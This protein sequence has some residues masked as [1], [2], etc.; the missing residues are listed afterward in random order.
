MSLTTWATDYIYYPIVVKYR[1]WNNY[2]VFIATLFTFLLIG[3]WHG[4]SVN[5]IIFGL[6][7]VVLI[8]FDFIIKKRK[9]RLRKKIQKPIYQYCYRFTS[10]LITFIVIAF[11]MMIFRITDFH[12]FVTI[13]SKIV[14]FKPEFYIGTQAYFIYSLIGVL[15]I[16]I[17]DLWEE[18]SPKT[19]LMQDSKYLVFRQIPYALF[20]IFIILIGV[21]DG[22]QFIYVQY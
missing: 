2:G 5:F 13:I 7:Q 21:F 22:G 15:S 6:L 16:F 20:I 10:W 11:S 12:Q 19:F 4:S 14:Q 8:F 1:D 17:I 9:N 18:F 3:I